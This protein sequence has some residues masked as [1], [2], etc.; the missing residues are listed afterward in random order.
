MLRACVLTLAL[1]FAVVS[2]ADAADDITPFSTIEDETYQTNLPGPA[3]DE[4]RTVYFWRPPSAEGTLPVLYMAD[5]LFGLKVAV[6]RLRPMILEGRARPLVVVAI[7]SSPQ[8]RRSKEYILGRERNPEWETHFAWFTGT[9]IP[10]AERN[11]GAS[12]QSEHRGIGG[13]SNGADFALAA[14]SRRPDLF[15]AVLAHSPVNDV[16]PSFNANHNARWALTVGRDEY[17]GQA[18]SL[19][20][21]I[22]VAMG[23]NVPLRRCVGPWG[24]DSDSWRDIS[25]GTI[26]WLMRLNDNPDDLDAPL[27]HRYC[28]TH[29]T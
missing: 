5:G 6:S 20:S 17:R 14:A 8:P 18:L 26:A 23:P 1:I 19:Q 11:A 3:A 12:N 21:R 4:T 16:P 2:T 10:W 15:S 29:D 28:E 27:E 13:F 22:V 24:H 9:V 25:P 7:E